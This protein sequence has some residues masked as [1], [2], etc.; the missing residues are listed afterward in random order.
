[1]TQPA[2]PNAQPL[3]QPSTPRPPMLTHVLE[4]AEQTLR[5]IDE[6]GQRSVQVTPKVTTWL[7]GQPVPGDDGTI[8]RAMF[9]DDSGGV[10][11]WVE[12]KPGTAGHQH[13][14]AFLVE[15]PASSV[16]FTMKTLPIQN[17]VAEIAADEQEFLFGEPDPGDGGAG[18]GDGADPGGDGAE[19]DPNGQLPVNGGAQAIGQ[20]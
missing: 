16:R 9:K 15:L 11:V 3:Q 20:G 5:V 8:V 13:G 4:H 12:P 10:R 17:L 7:L 19:G 1:M 6:N 18:D 14:L 2:D